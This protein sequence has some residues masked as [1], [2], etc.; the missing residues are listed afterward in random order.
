MM[1]SQYGSF[2]NYSTGYQHG[3]LL[4]P[5]P[6]PRRA[7]LTS[8][9]GYMGDYAGEEKASLAGDSSDQQSTYGGSYAPSPAIVGTSPA[10]SHRG[11][12]AEAESLPETYSSYPPSYSYPALSM[13]PPPPGEYGYAPPPP[14][15]HAQLPGIGSSLGYSPYVGHHSRASSRGIDDLARGPEPHET[16]IYGMAYGGQAGASY[17]PTQA[18]SYLAHHG[19]HGSAGSMNPISASASQDT[20]RVL[21]PPKE[22]RCWDHGCNGRVFS[23]HSNLLRHQREKSGQAAKSTC[24]R[25][26]AMFTRKT[27][28]N[29]HM[30][31]DKCKR[32]SGYS[33]GSERSASA[34]AR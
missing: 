25:C 27:A 13:I 33:S 5:P 14:H 18:G 22:S 7:S 26:G 16:T 23:T 29:G 32:K 9:T 17:I 31:H 3:R 4:P 19:H 2:G 12:S 21:D 8:T 30:L 20:V 10:L 1:P 28:M 11:G 15:H 6:P 34:G 24:P